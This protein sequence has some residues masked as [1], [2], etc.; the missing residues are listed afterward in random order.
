MSLYAI[1]RSGGESTPLPPRLMVISSRVKNISVLQNAL[2]NN[3]VCVQFK[4][5]QTTL[6]GILGE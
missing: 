3:V 1:R 2:Q 6:D 5:E 4:Y